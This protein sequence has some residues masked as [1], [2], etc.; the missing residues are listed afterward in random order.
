MS[1]ENLLLETVNKIYFDLINLDKH[2]YLRGMK[3]DG[4][5]EFNDMQDFCDEQI[6][7][8]HYLE[9]HL[10]KLFEEYQNE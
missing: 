7:K 10:T 9:I 8:L 4:F 5:N 1:I 6:S 2:T 3:L